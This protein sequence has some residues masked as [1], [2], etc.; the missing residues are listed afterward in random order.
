MSTRGQGSLQTSQVS[1]RDQLTINEA[2][3]R[4]VEAPPG[5]GE[6]APSG[7]F[8]WQAR[9]QD[10]ESRRKHSAMRL[11]KEHGNRPTDQRQLVA[12]RAWNPVDQTLSPKPAEI[13]GRLTMTIWLVEESGDQAHQLTVL[14]SDQHMAEAD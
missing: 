12:L 5:D 11:E 2:V 8:D 7:D 13:V 14:E 3:E 4:V 9:I 10:G 1:S 6:R